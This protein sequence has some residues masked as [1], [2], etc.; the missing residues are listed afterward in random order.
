MTATL[1]NAIKSNCIDCH[2]P[3]SRSRSITL[4][5]PGH[6]VPTAALVRSHFISI[7]PDE[8]KKFVTGKNFSQQ[9]K[10]N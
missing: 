3:A 10:K 1:G 6:E 2:M 4:M 7:Y 5:L 9:Q 8:V